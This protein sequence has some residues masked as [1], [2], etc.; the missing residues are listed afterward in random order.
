MQQEHKKWFGGGGGGW[1]GAVNALK[2]SRGP[3]LP[4]KLLN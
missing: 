4:E 3:R 1:E 2:L